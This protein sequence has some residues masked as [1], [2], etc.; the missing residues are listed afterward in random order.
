M[1]VSLQGGA[2]LASG[3]HWPDGAGSV[4]AGRVP[5]AEPVTIDEFARP[6]SDAV[7]DGWESL[8]PGYWWL[9]DGA[10]RRRLRNVGDRARSTGFPYHYETHGQAGGSMPIEYDPSLPTGILWRR[11]WFLSDGY[12][13]AIEGRVLD[14]TLT[15][16][17][18]DDASWLMYQREHTLIGVALAGRS[19]FEGYGRGNRAVIVGWRGDGTFGFFD[20]RRHR[21]R[22]LSTSVIETVAIDDA[23][24]DKAFEI[25]V[26]VAPV[27]SGARMTATLQVDG[28]RFEVVLDTPDAARFAHGFFGIAA[29]GLTDWSVTR[30]R[31]T[32]EHNRLRTVPTADLQFCYALGDTLERS[33]DG[34]GDAWT[35]RFMTKFRS[36]GERVE[37]RVSD[38]EAPAKGWAT[39]P[40]AG[41][42]PIVSNDY[43]CRT[44][45]VTV[46]LPFDPSTCTL[47]YT[48]WKDGRDVTADPRLGTDSVGAGTGWVGEVP[49]SGR[50]VGRLP[51][52]VAP[53][54]VCGL[55]CHAI[56]G[57]EAA[58][59]KP[60]LGE[61]FG[62]RDQPTVDA[63]RHLD[64]YDFQVML[65][66]DDVWYLELLIYPPSPEDAYKIIE[67]TLGGPTTR[68]QMMRH[69]NVINPGD[70][71]HGMDD[72]KGPEQLALRR[73]DDLGQDRDYMRRNFQIVSHLMSGDE[74]P[75]P[76]ANPR[77]WRR[78]Q[79]P[80][81]DFSLVVV[82]SRLWRSSQDT[83]IWDD[84]GWGDRPGLYGRDDPT[85]SLLGEE[86]FAW[87]SNIIHTD[88][89]DW[90]C[91][92][93][94][95][96]LHTIWAGV[97]KDPVSGNRFVERDRVAADYAGWVKAGCD[98][99][100]ELLAS[101]SGVISVYGD[102]HLGSV[103]RNRDHRLYECSFGPIGRTGGRRPKKNF[104]PVMEDYDG[105]PVDILA[106][107]HQSY[108]SPSLRK[109]TGPQYWNFLEMSFAPGRPGDLRL[110]VRNIIDAP[111]VEVRGGA[112]VRVRVS[113]TGRKPTASLAHVVT[114]PN[115]AVVLRGADGRAIRGGRSDGTGKLHADGLVDVAPGTAIVVVATRGE[116]A[117]AQVAR[118]A[119]V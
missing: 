22:P 110:A 7:G 23:L 94:I 88:P 101:R 118:A 116:E 52:L 89:A 30:V 5:L 51:K 74:S 1:Q 83:R 104:G 57:R 64:A 20:N 54:K 91:V 37:I 45:A 75:D 63:F 53:Y 47:Y 46:Q 49:N 93:G 117:H 21:N 4:D 25:T 48:V 72:V 100:I 19:Q 84:E 99:V 2:L 76:V 39:V 85:R 62:V 81:R 42:A 119:P 35:V 13:V 97:K 112:E 80:N 38:E 70:H 14:A 8:N 58:L 98:R 12:R 77:R 86:Q 10:L 43:R 82:D 18:G 60:R 24:R 56:H 67:L 79:M 68:W 40:V 108:D 107:Y 28:K 50:Y 32:P 29:R 105:R 16:P 33:S 73:H 90:I 26:D 106:L 102:V 69:W 27:D 96:G 65:W 36:D 55:S 66:E 15:V 6:D 92:S 59:P 103:A 78:W 17:D 3:A 34:R 95:N 87:L 111:D 109:R 41:A 71:D 9:R 114:L 113:D 61:A 11:D 44:A 31:L 115:A